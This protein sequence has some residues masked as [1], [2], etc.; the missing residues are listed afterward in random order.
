MDENKEQFRKLTIIIPVY[1]EID[2]LNRVITAVQRVKLSLEKE[3]ILIDDFSTDGT[4]ELIQALDESSVTKI[5]HEKNQGKGAA[6]RSG[7]QAATGDIIL[8][9]DADL[10]Y[11]PNEYP[12][13]LAPILEGKADV[14]YGSRFQGS[15]AHR[16]LYFWH[17]VGNKMLTLLSNMFT[18]INLTD[19]ETCYKVFKK[20]VLDKVVVCEDRFG[21]EPEIT[22]KI[23]KQKCRI[24]EI[25]ISYSGRSYEEGKKIGWR[26][27]VRAFWCILKYNIFSK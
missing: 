23:A 13:L 18:N 25:G 27:G 4:R 11:D 14:V 19:M 3:I 22:A 2:T 20:S 12:R 7:F 5:F 1:N 8:I 26:D 6:L 9:Q 21:F 16:V 15:K 17:S 10:E 24:Y